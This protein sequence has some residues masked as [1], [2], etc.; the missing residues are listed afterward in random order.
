MR[1]NKRG[2]ATEIK[3]TEVYRKYK[4]EHIA[5]REGMCLKVLFPDTLA[6][7]EE[8]DLFAGRG[9]RMEWGGVGFTPDITLYQNPH[10]MGYFYRE[11]VFARE[12][13]KQD[14]DEEYRNQIKEA[15]EFWRTENT[16]ARIKSTYTDRIK[17]ALPSDSFAGDVGVGF[18][19][20]RMT[21]AYE[22]YE[23]LVTLGLPGMYEEVEK[24]RKNAEA[25]GGDVKFY[26][27]MKLALDVFKDSCLYYKEQALEMAYKT[28]EDLRK[29]ELLEMAEVLEKITVSKPETMREAI[30]LFWLHTILSGVMD[31]GRMDIFLGD[32]L[33]SDIKNGLLTDEK[34]LEL[35]QS[36]WTLM[37]ARKTV[38]HGRV[39]IGGKG[40]RNEENADKFAMLAMEA[41]STVKAIE[42]QL[43]LRFY[44]G[45]NPA[46][47]EKGLLV[48]GEGRTY[49]MLY[50]DDVNIE[51]VKTAFEVGEEIAEQ[52]MPFG[53]GEYII[54]HKSFGSPNGVINLLKALEVTLNNGREVIYGRDMGLK[55]GEF[56]DFKTFEELYAAFK[57]QA[58]Y[59]IEI[60]AEQEALLYEEIGQISPFLFMSML[61]D[62]CLEKGKGMFAGGLDYL[63]GTLESYGNTNTVDSLV[64]IKELVYDKKLLTQEEMLKALHANFE[65]YERERRMMLNATKY[66]NDNEAAD[67][68]AVDLHNFMSHT[69][70]KQ[71]E[72]VNLHSYLMVI[73]N[74]S[75]NTYLGRWT[76][77][78][79]DG[80]KAKEFMAN[81]NNPTG[82]AD[83]NGITAMLNS[84]VKL[85]PSYHAGAV[86]NM[87]FSREMFNNSREK[88]KAL[89]D[90]YFEK[91]GAQ[92]MIS[93]LNRNDL[94]RA[95]VEPEK[96]QHVFVRVGGFSARFVELEKDVQQEILSRTLY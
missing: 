40:R 22:N 33:A 18:P 13:E 82:G 52:Y 27:G 72:R 86:Q 48:I 57:K 14:L 79:A 12:L 7:I 68:I 42:P 47:M 28:E 80:R 55:L 45:M 89:L 4:D 9:L 66:G 51:A 50:N 87:K 26:E 8:G 90:T 1:M 64:A 43:S 96:Y 81:A 34:A 6:P 20:Y 11:D 39:V 93:V 2:L 88:V 29:K 35:L 69:I 83:K 91:G 10:G 67:R 70:R 17:E 24:F 94:E 5:I 30:Q 73:I 65:G 53:C 56:K 46:L 60:L 76:G 84:L 74:N 37:V 19:L 21:G 49:P 23:K 38:Y 44:E 41:S 59:Y 95:M 31:Y 36:L 32:F 85:D 25:D 71:A 58:E 54:D 92:A 15:M 75:A 16:C 62:G 77:A 78:S 61:Y 3:F 63:G